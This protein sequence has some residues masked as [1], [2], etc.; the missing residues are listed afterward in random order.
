MIKGG[1]VGD[2]DGSR[3]PRHPAGHRPERPGPLS[4]KNGHVRFFPAQEGHQP[5]QPPPRPGQGKKGQPEERSFFP[6]APGRHPP[7]PVR[8]HGLVPLPFQPL[9]KLGG[10]DGTASG[11]I[12]VDEMQQT[13]SARL[14]PTEF[15]LGDG[16]RE[17]RFPS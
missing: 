3:I 15:V 4:M 6:Q 9:Q 7:L 8:R 10:D 14:H 1:A 13:A 2:V 12:P 11:P 5:R 17:L 16:Q